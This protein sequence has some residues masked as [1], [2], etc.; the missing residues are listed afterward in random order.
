MNIIN[1]IICYV[2]TSKKIL[3]T[4]MTRKAS[5]WS[6]PREDSHPCPC[7]RFD[8]TAIARSWQGSVGTNQVTFEAY[9]DHKTPDLMSTSD[10]MKKTEDLI[11]EDILHRQ[12]TI[13]I[14]GE[15]Q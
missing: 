4:I 3:L 6:P 5:C 10:F 2:H 15:F 12:E 13:L 7:Q 14:I 11:S 1:T 8:R 9:S